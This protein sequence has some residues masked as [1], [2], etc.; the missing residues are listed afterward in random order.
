MF[1]LLVTKGAGR[2]WQDDWIVRA[3]NLITQ[4]P[5]TML[6]QRIHSLN[7]MYPLILY[8]GCILTLFSLAYEMWKVLGWTVREVSNCAYLSHSGL[9]P[10]GSS[11][12]CSRIAP[13]KLMDF[14]FLPTSNVILVLFYRALQEVV[15]KTCFPRVLLILTL[16]FMSDSHSA[17]IVLTQESLPV[18]ASMRPLD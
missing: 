16:F 6:M 4:R 11:L 13:R 15:I 3:S 14:L 2:H 8:N 7:I 9:I 12:L 17:G 5:L 18:L 1:L 10:G